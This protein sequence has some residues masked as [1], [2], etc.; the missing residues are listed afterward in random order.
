M[1]LKTRARIPIQPPLGKAR[2]TFVFV[3]PIKRREGRVG[4]TRRMGE[5]LPYGNVI[6]ILGRKFRHDVSDALFFGQLALLKQQPSRSGGNGLGG[7][8]HTDQ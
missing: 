3:V 7:G 6:F 5:Q 1:V 8:K 2:I 4:K